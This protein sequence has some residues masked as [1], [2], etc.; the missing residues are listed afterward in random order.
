MTARL[1]GLGLAAGLLLAVGFADTASANQFPTRTTYVCD[2][3]GV[4]ATMN[5]QLEYVSDTGIVV[6]PGA[7]PQITGL[8]A[9][10]GYTVYSVGEVRGPRSYYT[11]VGENTY[12]DFTDMHRNERFRVRFDLR[13]G[14][15]VMV[16]NPHQPPEW[17]GRHYCKLVAAS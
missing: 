16:V 15:M 2:L 9:M 4:E 12:A 7:D 17:Q 11:F 14:G 3:G 1:L 5:V 13:Q 8:L 10:G 6:R